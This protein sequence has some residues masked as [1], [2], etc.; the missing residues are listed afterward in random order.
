MGPLK[1]KIYK[2]GR[3]KLGPTMLEN[4]SGEKI[5]P[6]KFE[7]LIFLYLFAVTSPSVGFLPAGLIFGGKGGKGCLK[8]KV[9][10]EKIQKTMGM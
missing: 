10:C 4:P 9:I 8:F 5:Y 7:F 6:P 2:S 3:K 1:F